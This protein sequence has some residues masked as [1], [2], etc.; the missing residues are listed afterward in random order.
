MR[1]KSAVVTEFFYNRQQTTRLT[2]RERLLDLGNRPAGKQKTDVRIRFLSRQQ[3]LDNLMLII[4][5]DT[6]SIQLP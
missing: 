3:K 1:K 4:F 5:N 6:Q 2:N